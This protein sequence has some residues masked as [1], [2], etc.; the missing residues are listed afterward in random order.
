MKLKL[1]FKSL[2]VLF[3]LTCVSIVTISTASNAAPVKDL[4]RLHDLCDGNGGTL[5]SIWY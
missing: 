1:N 3:L 5:D 2:L 4:T